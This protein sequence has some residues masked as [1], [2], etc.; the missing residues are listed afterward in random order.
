MISHPCCPLLCVPKTLTPPEANGLVPMGQPMVPTWESPGYRGFLAPATRAGSSKKSLWN[1]KG[2]KWGGLSLSLQG[3][4]YLHPAAGVCD[5]WLGAIPSSLSDGSGLTLCRKRRVA[6]EPS[7]TASLS[8]HK[9]HRLRSA[10]G[11]NVAWESTTGRQPDCK[12]E[13]S[14][15]EQRFPAQ[16][17]RKPPS[18]ASDDQ[19]ARPPAYLGSPEAQDGVG[20]PRNGLSVLQSPVQRQ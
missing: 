4:R 16:T 12:Q 7:E 13:Q 8:P 5:Q 9:H 2:P 19:T 3:A 17:P 20:D 14:R 10:D 18:G 15:W 6:V 11:R 1:Q